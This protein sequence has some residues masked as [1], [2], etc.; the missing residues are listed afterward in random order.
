MAGTKV[1]KASEAASPAFRTHTTSAHFERSRETSEVE[2]QPFR[3]IPGLVERL[4]QSM[5]RLPPHP[6]HILKGADP[7]QPVAPPPAEEGF[8]DEVDE[9]EIS[10][11]VEGPQEG[12]ADGVLE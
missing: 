5:R 8:E 3:I 2:K 12:G 7:L 4:T 6:A 10:E 1:P 11:E 9:M